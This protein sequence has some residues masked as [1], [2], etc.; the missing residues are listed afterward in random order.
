MPTKNPPRATL[1]R[2]RVAAAFH[3]ANPGA[4]IA[5]LVLTRTTWPTGR[6]GWTIALVAERDGKREEMHGDYLIGLAGET[7]TLAVR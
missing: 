7:D 4:R 2:R 6:T 3:R 5:S 1:V